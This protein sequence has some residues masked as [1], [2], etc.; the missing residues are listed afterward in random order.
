MFIFYF[1]SQCKEMEIDDIQKRRCCEV[2]I[3]EVHPLSRCITHTCKATIVSK[4]KSFEIPGAER[5]CYYE[6]LLASE[7]ITEQP[8]FQECK[9]QILCLINTFLFCF[10]PLAYRGTP[11]VF[12]TYFILHNQ[13][14]IHCHRDIFLNPYVHPKFQVLETAAF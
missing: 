6:H 14:N 10:F 12:W 4:I 11:D 8:Y 2:H 1:C 5:H 3:C 7:A 13:L 9:N